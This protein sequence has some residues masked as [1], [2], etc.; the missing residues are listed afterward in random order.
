MKILFIALITSL[1]LMTSC[2]K[3]DDSYGYGEQQKPS[4]SYETKNN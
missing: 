3:D 2:T 1:I 4:P